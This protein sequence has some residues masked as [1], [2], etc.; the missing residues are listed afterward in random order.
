MNWQCLFNAI[1]SYFE[2]AGQSS[3]YRAQQPLNQCLIKAAVAALTT[4]VPTFITCVTGGAG[5][6]NGPDNGGESDYN[7]GD[8]TRCP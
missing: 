2:C 6:G 1:Q 8:R 7:P 3:G 5:N 4:A